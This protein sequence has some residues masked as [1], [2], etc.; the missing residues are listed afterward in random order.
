MSRGGCV[1]GGCSTAWLQTNNAVQL[2]ALPDR[3]P[4]DRA[5]AAVDRRRSLAVVD[6]EPALPFGDLLFVLE[7]AAAV[8]AGRLDPGQLVDRAAI[9]PHPQHRVADGGH[10]RRSRHSRHLQ[11]SRLLPRQLRLA[12]G[13][14]LSSVRAGA[15][16][17]H[18]LFLVPADRLH[19]RSAPRGRQAASAGA[20]CALCFVLSASDRRSAAAPQRILRFARPPP[21][22]RGK[23][24]GS[25]ARASR[26]SCSA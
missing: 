4:A 16:A 14:R 23:H 10:R 24:R 20:L 15:A 25:T 9:R 26:S 18:Q 7:S 6:R 1:V 2:A 21:A 11:V 13:P 22:A 19:G 3:L 5:R 8:A 17:R 12:G